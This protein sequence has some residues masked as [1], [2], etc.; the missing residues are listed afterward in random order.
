MFIPVLAMLQTVM[1]T[2]PDL[3]TDEDADIRQALAGTS[4]LNNP[5]YSVGPG[6]IWCIDGTS[7]DGD[8]DN[9]GL[10]WDSP[11]ATIQPVLTT[12]RNNQAVLGTTPNNVW[13]WVLIAPGDYTEDLIVPACHLIGLGM[14]GNDRGVRVIGT[15]D[16]GMKGAVTSVTGISGLHLENIRFQ[17]ANAIKLIHMGVMNASWIKHCSF[18]GNDGAPTTVTHGIY[19]E[20][21]LGVHILDCDFYAI[22]QGIFIGPGGANK[23]FNNGEIAR[24]RIWTEAEGII[25]SDASGGIV[26]S[27]THIHDNIVCVNTAVA[28]IDVCNCAALLTNNYVSSAGGTPIIHDGGARFEIGNHSHDGTTCIDPNPA[29]T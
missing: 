6:R 18:R 10:D 22:N 9:D 23:F 11:K 28:G 3:K 1:G 7:G 24:N 13:D 4:V 8:D 26:V 25:I 29:K 14:W 17:S 19:I 27:G 15:A 5:L 12:I 21:S 20:N 16:P 2:I